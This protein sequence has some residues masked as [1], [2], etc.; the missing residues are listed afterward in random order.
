MTRKR[1][2]KLMRAYITELYAKYPV[3]YDSNEGNISYYYR[4][5]SRLSAEARRSLK[6]YQKFYDFLTNDQKG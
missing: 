4:N 1:F 2:E 3:L 5:L 6:S